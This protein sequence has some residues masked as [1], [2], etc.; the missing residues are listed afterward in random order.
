MNSTCPKVSTS[1]PCFIQEYRCL[2]LHIPTCIP[3]R[4]PFRLVN[5]SLQFSSNICRISQLEISMNDKVNGPYNA[6]TNTL[7]QISLTQIYFC[8]PVDK[9]LV[10]PDKNPTNLIDV[11]KNIYLDLI[12]LNIEAT[13]LCLSVSVG[14]SS[15]GQ[16]NLV[17]IYKFYPIDWWRKS[18]VEESLTKCTNYGR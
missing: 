9:T 8:P 2:N 1:G 16:S 14:D 3:Y 11:N 4:L 15:M 17:P 5:V 13:W 10:T 18:N 12:Q 6:R 7:D